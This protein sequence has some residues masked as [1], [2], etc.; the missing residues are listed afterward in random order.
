[1]KQLVESLKRLYISCMIQ[2]EKIV[3]LYQNNMIS[4][5]EMNFILDNELA[6]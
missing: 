6:K 3:E 5:N 4:E 2:E 1:M